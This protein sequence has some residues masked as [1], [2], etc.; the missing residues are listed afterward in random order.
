MSDK[1][2]MST[3]GSTPMFGL[4]PVSNS[5]YSCICICQIKQYQRRLVT[6]GAFSFIFELTITSCL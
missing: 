1:E 6:F 2:L 5:K 3:E 4:L